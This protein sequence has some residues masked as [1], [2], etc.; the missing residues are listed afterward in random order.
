MSQPT[1]R[2]AVLARAA[3][4]IARHGLYH[5]DYVVDPFNRRSDRPH[6]LRPMSAVGAINC[7]VSEDPRTPSNLSW[8]ALQ[9]LAG[10]V[11]VD[12]ELARS[13]SIEDCERHV[14]AWSDA[15]SREHVAQTLR[16]LAGRSACEVAMSAVAA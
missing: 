4:I 12:G 7:A 6:Y 3:Q 9:L 11:L 8:A 2:S 10:V 1:D 16:L 14:E 15:S 5:G 13:G